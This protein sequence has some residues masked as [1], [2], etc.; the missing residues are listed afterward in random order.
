VNDLAGDRPLRIGHKGAD[1]LAKGNTLESFRAAV[2]AGV[3]VVELD[4]LRPRS[5]FRDGADWR[6]ATAGPG[7][8][9]SDP[10]L[11]AH[12]WGDAAR[13]KPLT[14]PETLDAF[15]QPP[16]D[17][18]TIDLDLKVAGRE[19]EVVAAIAERDLIGRAM[20]ST[21][22]VASIRELRRL[23]P[24]LRLG[25]TVPKSTRNWPSIRW[26]RPLL[27]AGLASLRVRLPGIVRRRGPELG[28][29]SIWAYHLV[30]TRSLADACHAVGLDLNAWT[31]DDAA[32]IA[33]LTELGVDGICTNDPRLFA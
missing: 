12:D 9:G 6:R 31:V 17:R 30:I 11:V 26:A 22:E 23:T 25:W 28:V 21:M 5:D 27:V 8:A 2:D 16:L 13:R 33:V 1:A 18:V 29:N 32:R 24:E 15:L 7:A 20:A 4:V 3:D 10:L 14:L 19:D